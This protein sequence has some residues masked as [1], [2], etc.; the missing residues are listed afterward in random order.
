M[1]KGRDGTFRGLILAVVPAGLLFF[2]CGGSTGGKP[3]GGGGGAGAGGAGTGGVAATGGSAPGGTGGAVGTGGS[4]ATG[5]SGAGGATATGGSGGGGVGGVGGRTG[6]SGAG[7]AMATGG[8]GGGAAGV[9]GTAGAGTGGGGAGGN[10]T[11]G[12]GGGGAGEGG[13]GA[14]G[15][16]CTSIK[17]NEVLVATSI[18]A[19]EEFIELYN[20]CTTAVDLAGYRV[21]YRPPTTIVD[22]TIATLTNQTIGP[23]EF[24]VVASYLANGQRDVSF[25]LTVHLPDAGAVGIRNAAGTILDAVGYA[26]VGMT[27]S[28][29]L[30]EGLAATT[31]QAGQSLVRRPNGYDTN[32]N[33][34]N[35]AAA[36]IPSPGATNN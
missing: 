17:I 16:A 27:V 23:G 14:G 18:S 7:G 29:G 22:T 3:D 11:G 32:T 21:V 20:P 28:N 5:G 31:P 25:P 26:P 13:G 10:A 34:V 2:G 9:G 8:S 1:A 35:F 36:A 6:G 33:A 15:A 12:V 19:D 24:L 30:V 4:P